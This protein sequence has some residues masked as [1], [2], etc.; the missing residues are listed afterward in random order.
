MTDYVG[1]KINCEDCTQDETLGCSACNGH[2]YVIECLPD[3]NIT[4]WVAAVGVVGRVLF[5]AFLAVGAVCFAVI[6]VAL[7][8]GGF[9]Q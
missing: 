2:G 3:A 5:A 1:I 6:S 8:A 4:P 7:L 9:F